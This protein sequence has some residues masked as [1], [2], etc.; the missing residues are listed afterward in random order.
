MGIIELVAL[1]FS[2]PGVLLV[3]SM[4]NYMRFFGFLLSS[5]G[6]VIWISVGFENAEYSIM[7]LFLIY[8][9][10]NLMGAR[11]NKVDKKTIANVIYDKL[12][13]TKWRCKTWVTMKRNGFRI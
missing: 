2:I 7:G 13:N 3:T 4:L 11:K 12:E 8:M 5:I 9:V 1:C 6:N 10:I